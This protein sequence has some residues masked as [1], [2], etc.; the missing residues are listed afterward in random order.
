M[1]LIKKIIFGGHTRIVMDIICKL[2]HSTS[3]GKALIV[4]QDCF[5]LMN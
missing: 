1:T 3:K 4:S 2:E 5:N